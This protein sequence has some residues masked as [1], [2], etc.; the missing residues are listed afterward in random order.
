MDYEAN[1]LCALEEL[2]GMNVNVSVRKF[3][4]SKPVDGRGDMSSP[5]IRCNGSGHHVFEYFGRRL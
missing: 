3:G 4:A 2:N 1:V 5:L